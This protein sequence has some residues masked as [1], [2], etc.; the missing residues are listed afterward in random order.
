M[1]AERHSSWNIKVGQ[2]IKLKLWFCLITL[3]LLTA[4]AGN[5]HS[6]SKY[7]LVVGAGRGGVLF[8]HRVVYA[9]DEYG[10]L[11]NLN[12]PKEEE[13]GNDPEWS[14]DGRWVVHSYINPDP[15][16]ASDYDLYLIRSD[17][18][19]ESV[20]LTKNLG[21]HASTWSPDGSQIAF[22]AYDAKIRGNAIYI[23]K[24]G[25]ILRGENCTPTPTFVTEGVNPDWSPDGK[26]IVYQIRS[27]GIQ[28]V[29]IQNPSEIVNISHCGSSP[30]W[31]PDGKKIAFACEGGIYLVDP[32]GGNPISL[33]AG[34]FYPRWSPDGKKIAFIGGETLDPN[35]GQILDLEGMITSTAIFTMDTNGTNITRITNNNNESIGWFNWIL[36]N[37]SGIIP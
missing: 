7:A 4:C 36:M 35:L 32:D 24:V 12:I 17:N 15:R 33:V 30:Q 23:L 27:Q 5:I 10:A 34:A 26:K 18:T 25:C 19:Y 29:D 8:G 2:M 37:N 11:L 1:V 20:R 31:S 14:P 9:V 22:Y 28:V 16:S 13:L 21:P 3:M 6:T